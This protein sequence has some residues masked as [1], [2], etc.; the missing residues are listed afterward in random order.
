MK[1]PTKTLERKLVKAGYDL[2]IGVDEVGVGSLAGPVVVCATR[3][4]KDFYKKEHSNLAGLKESKLLSVSQRELFAR[5]LL[6]EKK[7]AYTISLCYPKKIDA[8]N[9]YQATR[10]AMR[11][12]IKNIS[13]KNSRAIVL[14]DGNK[15]IK[16]LEFDQRAIIK[17]DQKIFVIACASIIAKVYRDKMMKQYAKQ[18]PV[19]GFEQHKGYSTKTHQDALKRYG[20]CSIHRRSFR[21]VY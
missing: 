18:F 10:V 15:K 14:V 21:L 12:V 20:P 2:V 1:I 19:Y 16:N 4:T 11:R 3:F 6:K 13:L 8:I 9:I 7:L 17:G 5:K